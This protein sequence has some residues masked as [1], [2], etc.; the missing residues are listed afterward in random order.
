M[1]GRA[2]GAAGLS[3]SV[4]MADSSSA[5]QLPIEGGC[6]EELLDEAADDF[7]VDDGRFETITPQGDLSR[8]GAFNVVN[9]VSGVDV[10]AHKGCHRGSCTD[11]SLTRRRDA[12]L[13]AFVPMCTVR[14]RY[15]FRHCMRGMC[16][17][18][19]RSIWPLLLRLYH[20]A[21]ELIVCWYG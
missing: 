15:D 13:L 11:A 9:F 8:R 20:S 18:N 17:L 5:S 19:R 10:S 7:V 1:S 6:L 12:S 14:Y 4:D 2:A 16:S 3:S 21:L